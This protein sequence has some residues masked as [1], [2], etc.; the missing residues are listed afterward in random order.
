MCVHTYS[1]SLLS[2]HL[3]APGTPTSSTSL[4]TSKAK[5]KKVRSITRTFYMFILIKH[6]LITWL[7][8][9][10]IFII[11]LHW[12]S[13]DIFLNSMTSSIVTCEGGESRCADLLYLPLVRQRA[14]AGTTHL[15]ATPSN[16]RAGHTP[17]EIFGGCHFYL[18]C[19]GFQ[20]LGAIQGEAIPWGLGSRVLPG[21]GTVGAGSRLRVFV[22][23]GAVLPWWIGCFFERCFSFPVTWADSPLLL[24]TPLTFLL[25]PFF[26]CCFFKLSPGPKI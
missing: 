10:N 4:S 15:L 25:S 2:H 16:W 12:I 18:N 20:S 26:R 17:D 7:Y 13:Q 6:N 5:K 22:V 9:C 8:C 24:V 23:V 19:V 14:P 11:S 21:K 1:H 3:V